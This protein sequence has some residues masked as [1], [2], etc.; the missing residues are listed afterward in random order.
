MMNRVLIQAGGVTEYEPYILADDEANQILK[1]ASVLA[2]QKMKSSFPE[3]SEPVRR[4]VE[5]TGS[6]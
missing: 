4:Q 3:I 5:E 2:S 1:E 6:Q